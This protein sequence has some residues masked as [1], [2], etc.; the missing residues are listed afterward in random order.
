MSNYYNFSLLCYSYIED[1]C[2]YLPHNLHARHAYYFPTYA[3][4][5]SKIPYVL[6]A[7][8]VT[9]TAS[10]HS[11]EWSLSQPDNIL[12]QFGYTLLISDSV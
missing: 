2:L 4:V 9:D 6:Q 7:S 12:N 1:S 3:L 11:A 8:G 10:C 5:T